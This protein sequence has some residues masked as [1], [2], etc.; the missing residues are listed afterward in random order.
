MLYDLKMKPLFI[1][2]FAFYAVIC[3]HIAMG[4][5]VKIQN[6]KSITGER[7]KIDNLLNKDK[8]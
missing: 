8:I 3:E 1:W 6:Y 4:P 2:F 5:V 7:C